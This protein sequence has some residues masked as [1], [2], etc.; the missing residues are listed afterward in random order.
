[1]RNFGRIRPLRT[2]G[3]VLAALVAACSGSEVTLG[4]N[5]GEEADAL[6]RAPAVTTLTV[7]VVDTAGTRTT[8]GTATL[9]QADVDLSDAPRATLFRIEV[10]GRDADKKAVVFGRSVLLQ[11]GAGDGGTLPI[12]VQRTGEWA[13]MPR[14]MAD[15]RAYPILLPTSRTVL[16]AG[17]GDGTSAAQ[18]LTGYDFPSLAPLGAYGVNQKPRSMAIASSKAA[19]LLIGEDASQKITGLIFDLS[20]GTVASFDPPGGGTFDEVAGGPTIRG[21]DGEVYIVGPARATGAPTLRVLKLTPGTSENQAVATFLSFATARVGAA[22]AWVKNRG[23]LVFG[24]SDSDKGAEIILK[25]TTQGSPIDIAKDT[26]NGAAAVALDEKRVL[27]AGGTDGGNAAPSRIVDPSCVAKCAP[28]AWGAP[29][30]FKPAFAQLFA[31]GTDSAM[32]VAD[33]ESGATHTLRLDATTA[34]EIP[35]KIPRRGARA[36]VAPTGNIVLVGGGSTTVESY[37]P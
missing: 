37:Y 20:G 12:F 25:G 18:V 24:G 31:L 26:V 35:T 19:A 2:P 5:V 33:D 6:K 13:R 36:T 22:A 7:D 14:V 23:L 17:G 15:G 30:P 3:I 21:D 8:L 4:L 16:V 28:V 29:L 9:P 11:L 32:L 34:T 10:T 1:M 27:L